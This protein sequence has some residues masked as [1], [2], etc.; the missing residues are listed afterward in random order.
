M[1]QQ[2]HPFNQRDVNTLEF[3]ISLKPNSE[4]VVRYTIRYT[5]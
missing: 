4:A 5:W 1:L 2:N 3:P